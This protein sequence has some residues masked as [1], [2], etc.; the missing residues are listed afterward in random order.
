MNLS[1]SAATDNVGVAGYEVLRDGEL[2][3]DAARGD[4]LRRHRRRPG[5]TLRVH[6]AGT[7]PVRQPLERE[8][9]ATVTT[10]AAPDTQAPTA[11]AG[12]DAQAASARRVDL[13]WAAA[14]DDRGVT[15][16]EIL[17][18]RRSCSRRRA[19]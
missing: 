10:P 19:T 17:P 15:N 16:Y 1:W 6:R 14:T 13:S 4:E 9:P 7:R 5:D 12:L 18:R 3:R 8:R 11:P 2:D